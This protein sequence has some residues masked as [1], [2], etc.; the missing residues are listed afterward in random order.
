[1]GK[2][3]LDFISSRISLKG[4]LTIPIS[5]GP[6]VSVPCATYVLMKGFVKQWPT[7]YVY[8]PKHL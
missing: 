1:M 5:L 8:E 4:T 7:D 3:G 2:S 6:D